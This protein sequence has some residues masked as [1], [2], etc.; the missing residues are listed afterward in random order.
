M[1][2]ELEQVDLASRPNSHINPNPHHHTDTG[3]FLSHALN[4]KSR[5]LTHGTAQVELV[6]ATWAELMVRAEIPNPPQLHQWI[7]A[8]EGVTLA[9]FQVAEAA[10]AVPRPP[11]PPG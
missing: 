10:L 1:L 9:G 6:S 5:N 3:P 7:V 4:P 8:V 2:C 11:V